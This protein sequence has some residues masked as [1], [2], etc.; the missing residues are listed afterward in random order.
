VVQKPL[1]LVGRVDFFYVEATEGGFSN[2][3]FF[4]TTTGKT[5]NLE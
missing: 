3:R 2:V 5:K 4:E 1:L